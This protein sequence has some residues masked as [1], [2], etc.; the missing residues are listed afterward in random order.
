MWMNLGA[1]EVF[2]KG[3]FEICVVEGAEV[4]LLRR[5]GRSYLTLFDY[6]ICLPELTL[7][8]QLMVWN[9][10][11]SANCIQPDMHSGLHSGVRSGISSGLSRG[12]RFLL[13][14]EFREV[15]ATEMDD[16]PSAAQCDMWKRWL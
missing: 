11:V 5:V 7:A 8:D 2:G 16:P 3:D 1:S 4:F 9:F 12:G 15:I 14:F 6:Q 13:A 10:A